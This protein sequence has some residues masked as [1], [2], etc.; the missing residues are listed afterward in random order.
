VT[1]DE[2][3]AAAL[4]ALARERGLGFKEALN[5]TLRQGLRG[6]TS[7]SRP[8]VGP[9]FPMGIRPQVD[10]THALRL[11]TELEDQEIMRKLELGK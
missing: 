11:A 3:V 4:A 5:D 7:Q 2:D 9:T 10:I 8:Y 1:I 6:H